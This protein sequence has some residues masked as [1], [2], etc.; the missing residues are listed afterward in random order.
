MKA[1]L[2]VLLAS[3][4]LIVGCGP[5]KSGSGGSSTNTTAAGEN[6]LNAPTDYL[7]AA[8]KAKQ[9][10]VRTVDLAS[11]TRAIQMFQASEGRNPRDLNELVTGQYM[12]RLPDPPT[13]MKFSYNPTTAEVKLVPQ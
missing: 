11:V 12:P 6:P 5:S 10:A 7:G 1:A 3:G 4:V 2:S 8:A 13:G 9:S